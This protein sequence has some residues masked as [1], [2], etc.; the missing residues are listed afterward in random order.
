MRRVLLDVDGVL[1]DFT[2][3]FRQAAQLACKRELP[4]STTTWNFDDWQ[5]TDSERKATWEIVNRPGFTEGLDLLWGS[6]SGVRDLASVCEVYFVT[7]PIH[8]S[9]TWGYE[10]HRW[11]TQQF[12][13]EQ[14]SKVVFTSHKHLVAGDMLV[15]DKPSNL[16]SWN[17]GTRVLWDAPYNRESS[18]GFRTS[19]WRE[20][21]KLVRSAL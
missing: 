20:V 1:A 4:S 16:E 7:S 2:G 21:L 18:I 8:T 15:D 3:G 11:L 6:L 12:G 17:F 5:L 10:R 13:R 14:G 9:P 19:D